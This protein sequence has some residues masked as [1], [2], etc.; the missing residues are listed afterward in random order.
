LLN[1]DWYEVWLFF[2]FLIAPTKI[3]LYSSLKRFVTGVQRIIALLFFL[4]IAAGVAQRSLLSQFVDM[5]VIVDNRVYVVADIVV[6]DRDVVGLTI[7]FLTFV[8]SL[9]VLA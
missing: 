8:W 7:L 9:A 6:D 3:F 2:A 5:A 1:E 4:R